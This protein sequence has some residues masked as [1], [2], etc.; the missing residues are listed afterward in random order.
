[1]VSKKT[2]RCEDCSYWQS[3]GMIPLGSQVNVGECKLYIETKKELKKQW[4]I[5]AEDH[6]CG[7]FRAKLN[8]QD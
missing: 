6:R 8:L 3:W 7:H 2:N 4:L 1:M 5:V